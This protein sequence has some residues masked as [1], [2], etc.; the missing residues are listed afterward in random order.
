MSGK[1]T[2]E[3]L[4]QLARTLFSDR[5]K[6]LIQKLNTMMPNGCHTPEMVSRL[7][8]TLKL[9]ETNLLLSLD[10][11][12]LLKQKMAVVK[13]PISKKDYLFQGTQEMYELLDS[14][15]TQHISLIMALSDMGIVIPNTTA[16]NSSIGVRNDIPR[17]FNFS[18]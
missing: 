2:T 14:I 17:K 9:A 11:L 7:E 1:I 6:A 18:S 5:G 3:D 16:F 12:G 8:N 15:Q 10:D 4:N 13:R